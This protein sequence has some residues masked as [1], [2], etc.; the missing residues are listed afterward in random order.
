MDFE[1]VFHD[2]ALE[3]PYDDPLVPAAF[4]SI[5]VGDFREEFR[6]SLHE[7]NKKQYESQWRASIGALLRGGSC[8]ALITE[9]HSPKRSKFFQ[10]WILYRGD[11]D[12]IHVQNQIAFYKQMKS[13]FTAESAESFARP[14]KTHTE[15][16]DVISEWDTTFADVKAFFDSM[17]GV[18]G[19]R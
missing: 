10:W 1:I 16:G 15:D 13:G 7:W 5:R 18:K 6:S 4:G 12:V 11:G 19:G 3:Y 2:D 17:P 8:A 14:R 9:Y